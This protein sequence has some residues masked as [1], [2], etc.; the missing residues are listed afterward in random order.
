MEEQLKEA[1]DRFE[2]LEKLLAAA[3]QKPIENNVTQAKPNSPR[4]NQAP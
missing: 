4:T 1:E 2:R 3:N